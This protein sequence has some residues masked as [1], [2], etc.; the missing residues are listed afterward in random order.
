MQLGMLGHARLDEQRGLGGINPGGEPVDH[1]FP[2][3]GLDHGGIV[4]MGGQRVPVGHEE[5]A[6]Q[7]G[8]QLDPV[9]QGTVI[10]AQVQRARGA[11]A[12]DDAVRIHGV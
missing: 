11:H 1:H 4:V 8:L 12:G 6:G 3:A 7:L 9:L 5:Q 2:G 10:V